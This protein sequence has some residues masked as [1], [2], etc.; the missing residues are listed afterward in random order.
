MVEGAMIMEYVQMKKSRSV[1]EIFEI[2]PVRGLKEGPHPG[3]GLAGDL[4][5]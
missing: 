2:V 4:L 1:L 3:R 5:P